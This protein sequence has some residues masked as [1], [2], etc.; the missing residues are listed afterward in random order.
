MR[1][2]SSAS[3]PPVPCSS[4]SSPSASW[5]RG[6]SGSARL[7]RIR[8]R[9]IRD[10]AD[11]QRV[12]HRR[13]LPVSS[14]SRSGARRWA[15]SR[16][17]RR[18]AVRPDCVRHSDESRV[19]AR[20]RFHGRW[21]SL[22]RSAAAWKTARSSSTRSTGQMTGTTRSSPPHITGM[23]TCRRKSCESATSNPPSICRKPIP[24]IRN[25]SCTPPRNLT[26]PRSMYSRRWG[27]T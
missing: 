2:S 13:R 5:R 25:G 17:R 14:V 16:R 18:A 21:T 15:R 8:G 27:S 20:W 23:P 11:L 1:R 22:V 10:R 4:P 6:T 12:L 24:P 7:P 9:S 3:T 19:P 26:T